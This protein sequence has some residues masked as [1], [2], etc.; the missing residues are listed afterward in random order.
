MSEIKV[1]KTQVTD[2]QHHPVS[3]YPKSGRLPT[4][5]NAA[6]YS[7]SHVKGN[8]DPVC[9][10]MSGLLRC[11]ARTE[12]KNHPQ[13]GRTL[14]YF[15][16]SGWKTREDCFHWAHAQLTGRR[17]LRAIRAYK[18]MCRIGEIK[19]QVFLT[20][21]IICIGE[22]GE[23]RVKKYRRSSGAA[24]SSPFYG[25]QAE[26]SMK[27]HFSNFSLTGNRTMEPYGP[28]KGSTILG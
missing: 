13:R 27:D 16:W 15:F 5:T 4:H 14:S 6:E 11:H 24:R 3:M 8:C 19:L 22:R 25:R 2:H 7:L 1:N 21:L 18:I 17:C 28:R 23:R 26:R 12:F 9:A 10:L 20:E